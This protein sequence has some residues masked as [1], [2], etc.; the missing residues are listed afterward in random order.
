MAR[1]DGGKAEA[2]SA[3]SASEDGSLEELLTG[4]GA[5]PERTVTVELPAELLEKSRAT[6]KRMNELMGRGEDFWGEAGEL[7]GLNYEILRIVYGD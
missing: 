3:E 6:G 4:S 5:E 2:D 7:E 1:T